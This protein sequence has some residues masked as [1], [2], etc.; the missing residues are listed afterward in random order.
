MLIDL[1]RWGANTVRA[2]LQFCLLA[3]RT[4]TIWSVHFASISFVHTTQSTRQHTSLC[5]HLCCCCCCC[6]Q[7][8]VATS[9]NS[10]RKVSNE[11][12]KMRLGKWRNPLGRILKL[13][14]YQSKSLTFQIFIWLSDNS[15]W[16]SDWA[17]Y[18]TLLPPHT[19]WADRDKISVLK[20]VL[21]SNWG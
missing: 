21:G 8:L 17:I 3:G 11:L 10:L 16:R 1:P 5:A 15:V 18:G 13:P 14:F 4:W 9:A 20:L 7:R 12:W 6:C 2:P 19:V